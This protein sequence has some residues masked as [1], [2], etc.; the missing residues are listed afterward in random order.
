MNDNSQQRL[1]IT[2][3]F[4]PERKRKGRTGNRLFY[5]MNHLVEKLNTTVLN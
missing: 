5:I 4:I 1:P 3:L 2:V